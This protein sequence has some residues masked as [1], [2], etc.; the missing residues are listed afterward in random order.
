MDYEIKFRKSKEN[1][2][3]DALSR[4]PTSRPRKDK[5]DETDTF[6]IN[7]LDN[8]PLDVTAVRKQTLADPVLRLFRL[9]IEIL[10]HRTYQP[11]N[12]NITNIATNS[13]LNKAASC[14]EFG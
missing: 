2:N 8:T 3:A 14:E 7:H 9:V 10:M 4:L 11:M 13:H 1:S 12:S 5:P 6:M